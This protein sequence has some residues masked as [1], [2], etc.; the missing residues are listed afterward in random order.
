MH[1]DHIRHTVTLRMAHPT[2]P[3]TPTIYKKLYPRLVLPVCNVRPSP[4]VIPLTPG[5][6]FHSLPSRHLSHTTVSY[7]H[8]RASCLVSWFF[9]LC[10]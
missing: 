8:A 4:A 10:F 1:N 9:L 7:V 2:L 6:N 5:H 3:L